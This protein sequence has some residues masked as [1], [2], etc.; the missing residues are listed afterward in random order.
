MLSFLAHDSS[1]RWLTC[2]WHFKIIA[3]DFLVNK[4]G[5]RDL[6]KLP[7]WLTLIVFVSLGSLTFQAVIS[8]AVSVECSLTRWQSSGAVT[9]SICEFALSCPLSLT[10][11]PL[12]STPWR[13]GCPLFPSEAV[14]DICA[15]TEAAVLIS[16]LRRSMTFVLLGPST[17]I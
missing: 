7:V 2:W 6:L 4:V 10:L 15:A 5:T 17:V 16:F 8:G 14:C 12:A 3:V 13:P 11:S 9:G 1:L